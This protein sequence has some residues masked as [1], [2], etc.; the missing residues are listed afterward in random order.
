[1]L[2]VKIETEEGVAVKRVLKN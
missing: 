2:F 1:M